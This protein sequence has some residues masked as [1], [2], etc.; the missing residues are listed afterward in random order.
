ME[1][2]PNPACFCKQLDKKGKVIEGAFVDEYPWLND[3]RCPYCHGP[4]KKV[5]N[6][7]ITQ[8]YDKIIKKE[9]LCDTLPFAS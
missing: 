4:L 8:A 1:Y 3:N 5:T 7:K 9:D 2:C 6:E